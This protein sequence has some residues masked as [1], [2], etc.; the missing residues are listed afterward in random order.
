MPKKILGIMGEGESASP[1]IIEQAFKLGQLA[2]ADGWVV[3]TGGRNC[4]VMHAA[5]EG[6][7]A[8][9]GQ[10]LAILPSTDHSSM[11]PAADIRIVTALSSARNHVNVLTSDVVVACGTGP[12]TSSEICLAIKEKKPV[13]LLGC[14]K[15]G[16]AFF[17]EIGGPLVQI[18]S[19]AQAAYDLVVRLSAVIE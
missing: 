1:E 8:G 19:T 7:K 17:Q 14:S 15:T 18:A 10:T 2:A 5:L 16:Q 13:I 9:G 3:L 4:G 12:G 11:S 6:A